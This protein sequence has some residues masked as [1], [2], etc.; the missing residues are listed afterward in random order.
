MMGDFNAHIG[1]LSQ[2]T[3]EHYDIQDDFNCLQHARLT[4]C[5]SVNRA[6]KLFLDISAAGF[7]MLT[8]GRGKGDSGQATFVGYQGRHRSRPDHILATPNFY[9]KMMSTDIQ[10]TNEQIADHCSITA[11]FRIKQGGL[12]GADLN[13]KPQHVCHSGCFKHMLRWDPDKALQCAEHL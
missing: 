6:G 3:D 13:L 2:F 9:H 5:T 4:C 12:T 1:D 10:P 8:T 11:C 7:Y